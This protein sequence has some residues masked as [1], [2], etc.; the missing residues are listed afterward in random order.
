MFKSEI[1]LWYEKWKEKK[2]AVM[3][4]FPVSCLFIGLLQTLGIK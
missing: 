3:Q 1:Q 4:I 2:S